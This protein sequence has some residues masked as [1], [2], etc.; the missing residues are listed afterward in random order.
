MSLSTFAPPVAP[1]PQ[2]TQK[3]V[4]GRVRRAE[5][6]DGYSQRAPDGLNF[7]GRQVT[8]SWPALSAADSDTIE[9][10]FIAQNSG[11]T[12]FLYT[13]YNESTQ[14][15][16]TVASWTKAYVDGDIVSLTATLVQE[17]DL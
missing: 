2:G 10:F 4:S 7:V 8:L 6:G 13:L 5:F 16:W 15:Q 11:A 9:A 17:F 14:Y 12:P 1:S 3:Q